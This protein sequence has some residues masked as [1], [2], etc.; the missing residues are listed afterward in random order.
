ME[1]VH[2]TAREKESVEVAFVT[3]L[4]FGWDSI[5]RE[6]TGK[7]IPGG[8]KDTCKAPRVEQNKAHIRL[9]VSLLVIFIFWELPLPMRKGCQSHLH[10]FHNEREHVTQGGLSE[11][12]ISQ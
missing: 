12:S 8:R 6:E 4:K 2:L 5:S 10:P 7:G 11:N 3:A 9:Q 1:E